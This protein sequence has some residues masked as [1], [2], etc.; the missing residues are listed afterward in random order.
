MQLFGPVPHK[1]QPAVLLPLLAVVFAAG[2]TNLTSEAQSIATTNIQRDLTQ[3]ASP[4]TLETNASAAT[5][6]D[7]RTLIARNGGLDNFSGGLNTYKEE[8]QRLRPDLSPEAITAVLTSLNFGL[9]VPIYQK[10]FTK[11]EIKQMIAFQ[12]SPLGRKIGTE[13]PLIENE[14]S[15]AGQTFGATLIERLKTNVQLTHSTAANTSTDQTDRP[16]F[17]SLT[18]EELR[19]FQSKGVNTDKDFIAGKT[20]IFPKGWDDPDTSQ[21]L[22]VTERN[23]IGSWR[24]W[25]QTEGVV[26]YSEIT[27]TFLPDNKMNCLIT[28]VWYEPRI[29]IPNPLHDYPSNYPSN[30]LGNPPKQEASHSYSDKNGW[31]YSYSDSDPPLSNSHVVSGTWKLVD[32]YI[33]YDLPDLQNTAEKV[34]SLTTNRLTCISGVNGGTYIMYHVSP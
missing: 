17:R 15:I 27:M 13:M 16:I 11:D 4:F 21:Q 1:M 30:S 31:S 33:S 22:K 18:S 28:M 9:A 6:D 29:T 20:L 2:G 26:G 34:A 19:Y 5:D 25:N 32:G 7:I 10:H 14:L 23:I 3:V 12:E 8:F 24:R